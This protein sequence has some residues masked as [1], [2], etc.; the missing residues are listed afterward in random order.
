MKSAFDV[1]Q[2]AVPGIRGLQ[3]YQPGK[4]LQE[5]ER[6]YGVRD[7][8][9]LASNENPLGPSPRALAAVKN[10]LNDLARYPDGSGILLKNAIALKLGVSPP[11]IALGNG[12]NDILELAARIFVAPGEKVLFSEY[13]FAIYPI[14]T[15]AVGGRAA[16]APARAWA[17][18]L[19]AMRKLLS[20]DIKLVF[21]A[22]P[23]NPTG[24]WFDK[25][26]LERFLA[27][28]SP[29]TIV[30]LDEAYFEYVTEPGYPDG[31]TLLPHYP[32]LI[33]TRTFSK[34]CG[35]AG[36]RVGY[37]VSSPE[38]ADLFNRARQPF[39]VNSLA[40]LAAIAALQDAAHLRRSREVNSE[41]MR[42][43]TQA[44]TRMGLAFIPSV[45][46]FVSVDV[47]RSGAEVYEAL[48]HEGVIVRPM[49]GYNMPRHVRVTIGLPEENRRFL[50]ALEK[51]LK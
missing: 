32:N 49:D 26:A 27:A 48:L 3:P 15:Q 51:I 23:N 8:I 17:H 42:Q 43:L 19:A 35:L 25:Q 12:S 38:I 6:E 2:L 14:A 1:Y 50:A 5:L 34:I 7:A 11:Q 44:F 40:Q 18:D 29:Q 9:K 47:G 37:G 28:V 36:L 10:A 46:N 39:N 30:L 13:A 45:A 4:P 22:N 24:T 20:P 41:G 31:L 33:V 21:L 16:I